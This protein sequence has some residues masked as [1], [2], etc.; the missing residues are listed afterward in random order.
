M[1]IAAVSLFT[2]EWIEI[3]WLINKRLGFFNVSLFTRE[4]IE[5]PEQYDA[6]Q[7][8]IVSLFTREWIEMIKRTAYF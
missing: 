4:W 5:I 6:L 1:F 3:D 7:R 8:E 2:R